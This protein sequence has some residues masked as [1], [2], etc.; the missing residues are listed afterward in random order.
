MENKS[1]DTKQDAIKT[2]EKGDSRLDRM[3]K[4]DYFESR[5]ERFRKED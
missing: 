5:Y 2:T 1:K 3:I 4:L